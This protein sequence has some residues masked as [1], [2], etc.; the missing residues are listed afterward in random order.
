MSERF[1]LCHLAPASGAVCGYAL[2]DETTRKQLAKRGRSDHKALYSDSKAF[3]DRDYVLIVSGLAPQIV[4]SDTL[5]SGQF[6]K[7]AENIGPI[8]TVF[9]GGPC[10]GG[11][12]AMKQLADLLKDRK[13]HPSVRMY[14]SPLTQEVYV[15]A[16]KKRYLAPIAEAG[17]MILPPA[18]SIEDIPGYTPGTGG[19]VLATPYRYDERIDCWYVSHLTAAES[20]V[21]GE[22]SCVG[23]Q[24]T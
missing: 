12:E 20:A 24:S 4:K 8:D 23:R 14:I 11:I 16:I 1:S 9:V 19:S 22:L 18:S 10:G 3:Y 15:E 21:Q 2:F 13:V 7:D 6:V 5:Q 17:V